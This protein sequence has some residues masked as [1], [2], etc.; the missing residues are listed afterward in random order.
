LVG[1]ATLRNIYK[2][3]KEV[4]KQDKKLYILSSWR[5]IKKKIGK[6]RYYAISFSQAALD[7]EIFYYTLSF[8]IAVGGMYRSNN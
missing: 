1:K 2:W 4:G 5:E 3:K 6:Y 7:P 8:A